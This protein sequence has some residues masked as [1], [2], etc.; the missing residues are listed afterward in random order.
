MDL[1][2]PMPA[3]GPYG[4]PHPATFA[5]APAPVTSNSSA[6]TSTSS[7]SSSIRSNSESSSTAGPRSWERVDKSGR[8]LRRSGQRVSN[9]RA[10]PA[11]AAAPPLRPLA[12]APAARSSRALA[13]YQHQQQQQQQ[14]QQQP[15]SPLSPAPRRQ[16][17]AQGTIPGSSA[18]FAREKALRTEFLRR[19]VMVRDANTALID[20][21]LRSG[22]DL[23]PRGGC[24]APT[25]AQAA[26]AELRRTF[27]NIHFCFL[28]W[29]FLSFLFLF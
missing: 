24:H 19:Q 23:L 8:P 28:R 29:K 27:Y 2:D 4:E 5:C 17:P 1:A 20:P 16:E 12:P 15:A 25:T 18:P 3:Y 14:Q 21:V 22:L 11:S 10:G 6:T 13:V 9:G 7:R 26:I